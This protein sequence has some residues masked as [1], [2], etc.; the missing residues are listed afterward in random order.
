MGNSQ[1]SKE[2]GQYKL[3]R[4][5]LRL[6]IIYGHSSRW[7]IIGLCLYTKLWFT[8]AHFLWY[9]HDFVLWI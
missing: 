4:E 8:I 6:V 9:F 5:V 2:K 7:F 3:C 1:K